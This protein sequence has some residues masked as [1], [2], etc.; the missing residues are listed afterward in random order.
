MLTFVS[1][2]ALSASS[3]AGQIQFVLGTIF[4]GLSSGAA[5]LCAQYWGKGDTHTIE[6]VIGM[7]LRYSMFI[8]LCFTLEA[9]FFP[10]HTDA[11]IYR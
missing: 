6:R 9:A 3:L 1:Q 11:H 2:T 10:K 7:N 4:F 8:G 5:V